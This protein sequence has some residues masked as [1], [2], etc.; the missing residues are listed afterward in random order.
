MVS[1]SIVIAL[2]LA[3]PASVFG[4]HS[5]FLYFDPTQSV[6][7]EG[8]ISNLRWRNPHVAFMLDATDS[9]GSNA[10]WTLETHSVSI[11]RR[12]DIDRDLVG[13]GDSVKVAGWRARRGG[14]EIFVTN[15]L[16]PNGVEIAFDPGSPPRWTDEAEGDKSIWLATTDNATA[17]DEDVG[18]FHVWSTSLAAGEEVLLF[19][20]YDFPLTESAAAA[21]AKYDMYTNPI[22]GTCNYK[23]MPTIMEQPYPMQFARS[24]DKILM[25]MEEGN[26]VRVFDMTPGAS[27]EGKEPTSLGHSVG[28][29]Q[30]DTL[31]VT[32]TGSTWPWIDMTGVPNTPEAVYIE[33]FTATADGKVLN[34]EMT[35]TAPGVLTEP[36]KFSKQWLWLEDASVEPY[37]CVPQNEE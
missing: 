22:I 37:D 6:E 30:G 9:S 12:M 31:V 33:R 18:I 11:L 34:Y 32:T 20:G 28:E 7:L 36:A 24:Q 15:M 4:H 29:W 8:T 26:I 23:G 27:V 17:T 14:N 2:L 21:R 25:H 3:A 19:E 10:E 5:P 13:I 35:A 16:L 1:R